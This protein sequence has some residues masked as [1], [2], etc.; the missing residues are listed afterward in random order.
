[1]I[2]I[3]ILCC[4]LISSVFYRIF[5][6]INES[7]MLIAM[8]IDSMQ[9]FTSCLIQLTMKSF[10]IRKHS[11]PFHIISLLLFIASCISLQMFVIMLPV[12]HSDVFLTSQRYLPCATIVPSCFNSQLLVKMHSQSLACLID[13][14]FV[15]LTDTG[16]FFFLIIM[17]MHV[18]L[19]I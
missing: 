17:I 12:L 3:T 2:S 14:K 4:F 15:I 18:F 8:D 6:I 16:S 7:M 5:L 19:R 10:L 9:S 13:L 11:V 1:M